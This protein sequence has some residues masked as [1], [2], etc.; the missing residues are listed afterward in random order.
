MNL[1]E[2]YRKCELVREKI[3]ESLYFDQLESTIQD[4][5]GLATR[6]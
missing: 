4:E 2:Q 1:Y 3:I 5:T 6:L